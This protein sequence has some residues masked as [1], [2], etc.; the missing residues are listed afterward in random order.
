M[1]FWLAKSGLLCN[2]SVDAISP[3]AGLRVR[4]AN[5][6]YYKMR[7]RFCPGKRLLFRFE[8]TIDDDRV[9]LSPSSPGQSRS[10]AI[11]YVRS[12]VYGHTLRIM[13]DNLAAIGNFLWIHC[14][15]PVAQPCAVPRC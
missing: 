12:T 1:T 13:K 4:C 3:G 9:A 6:H 14:T 7:S 5:L 15:M 11:H 2:G 10:F 8:K